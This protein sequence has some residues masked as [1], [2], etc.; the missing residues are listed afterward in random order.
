MKK[1]CH[2]NIVQLKEVL[3]DSNSREIYLVLEYLEGGEVKWQQAGGGIMS[4]DEARKICRD[5]I[6]GLEYL[7]FQ[8]IIHRD[9]K[10]A[11]LLKDRNGTVK[12]SDFGVSYAS[13]ISYPNDEIELA[14]TAGTPAFFAPELCVASCS[15]DDDGNLK[16]QKTVT[17]K[18]DIWAFGVT[19]YCLLFGKVPFIA[20]SEFDLFNVIVNEPLV[21]PDEVDEVE[22]VEATEEDG[23]QSAF[24]SMFYN[25]QVKP[26]VTAAAKSSTR[27]RNPSVHP[28]PALDMAKDLLRHV[29]EKDP[30]KRYDIIDIKRHK[31]MLT[32]MKAD[33]RELFLT[34]TREDERIVVTSEDVDKAVL[35]I[36]GRLKKK[37]SRALQIAGLGRKSSTSS[38]AASSSSVGPSRSSSVDPAYRIGPP[39]RQN[40]KDDRHRSFESSGPGTAVHSS[41]SLTSLNSNFSSTKGATQWRPVYNNSIKDKTTPSFVPHEGYDR[42]RSSLGTNCFHLE[43]DEDY[44]LSTVR[45]LVTRRIPTSESHLNING[46]LQPDPL[47]DNSV[48]FGS[49]SGTI[50]ATSRNN[51]YNS[52][53]SRSR[54]TSSGSCLPVSPGRVESPGRVG[55][56]LRGSIFEDNVINSEPLPMDAHKKFSL[57]V[58]DDHYNHYDG[59]DDDNDSN[60]FSDDESCSTSSSE[61]G[62]EFILNVGPARRLRHMASDSVLRKNGS[63]PQQPLTL[64]A[65][66]LLARRPSRRADSGSGSALN[67]SRRPST[68]GPSPGPAPNGAADRRVRSSSVAI[69]VIQNTRRWR[70]EPSD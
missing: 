13:S 40:S 54:P 10:P 70:D 38:S 15:S 32:G 3:D 59:D 12:I 7:H 23:D 47:V 58:C 35:G 4:Q 11:N 22:E 43:D 63:E 45:P 2:P 46:L 29:L 30:E 24:P 19:L 1:C 66:G 49:S 65:T 53:R 68:A 64:A 41:S 26:T 16:T 62:E 39:S 34:M 25:P 60:N 28:D 27:Q 67:G 18:I 37:L 48:T 52:N 50:M 57:G 8:G 61:S 5:V 20:V 42:R 55:S 51:N 36:R 44:G 9:I 69:G 6:S 33:E 21:F 56:P 31:W 14:K 17:S